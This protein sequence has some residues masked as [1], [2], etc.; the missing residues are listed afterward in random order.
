MKKIS[1]IIP[2][3]NAWMFTKQCLEDLDNLPKDL[4]EIIVVDNGSSD[5]TINLMPKGIMVIKNS[6]NEGFAKACN[7]G[8]ENSSGEYVIFLNND[9]KVQSNKV[10]WVQEFID[11]IVED[12][13][14]S[15][16]IGLIDSS[17]NFVKE[18]DVMPKKLTGTYL[19]GWCL[20]GKRTTFNKL[21]VP[22]NK[23]KGPFEEYYVT[24][25][26]DTDLS[27]RARQ[28][29]IKLLLKKVPVYHF[30][31]MTS[32]KIGI[33]SLYVSARTKFIARWKQVC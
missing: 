17:F 19:S 32:R 5:E 20:G 25:F 13:L 3:Y 1:I 21:I 14:V 27:F 2:V 23:Y 12:E 31:K 15:P 9:I 33:S 26:E 6:S 7:K 4:V 18:T 24:Y 30:G 8:F 28:Q 11:S 22:S 10:N 16:N 29:G